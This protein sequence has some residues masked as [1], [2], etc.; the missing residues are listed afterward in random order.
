MDKD[1]LELMVK[2][3]AIEY[4]LEQFAAAAL[5]ASHPSD[6][7][8]AVNRAVTLRGFSNERLSRLTFPNV[9]PALADHYSDELR[10]AVDALLSRIV[11]ATADRLPPALR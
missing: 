11:Q 10:N 9:E 8:Q 3:D 1:K 6:P 4:V 7:Q 5:M 2:L